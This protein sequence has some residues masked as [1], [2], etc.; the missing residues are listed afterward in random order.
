MRSRTPVT[1]FPF[2]S[3]LVSTMGVLSF[4]AVTFLMLIRQEQVPQ[5]PTKPVEVQWVG[6]PEHVRPLLV[7]C[8]EDGVVFH[9]R[10]DG[11]SHFFPLSALEDEVKIVKNLEGQGV[12][13]L[14][15]TPDSYRFWLFMK[16]AIQRDERLVDSLTGEFNNLELYNLSGEG[17][18][19]ITQKYPILLIFPKGIKSYQMASYLVE[20]TTR[21]SVG[22]EPMLEGWSLP[23]RKHA[24]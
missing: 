3:V 18:R 21:L 20:T 15:A 7:E 17:R 8:R 19:N 1:L 10:L 22:L 24:S 23:Y 6:A 2:L 5:Q 13:G 12:E 16:N 14:G 4:L 9:A 11:V